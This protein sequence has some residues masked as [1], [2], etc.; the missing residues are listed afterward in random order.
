MLGDVTSMRDP[1]FLNMICRSLGSIYANVVEYY[2][3]LFCLPF[4]VST[5]AETELTKIRQVIA[6]TL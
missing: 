1:A 3:C 4:A 6:I 2:A 5:L